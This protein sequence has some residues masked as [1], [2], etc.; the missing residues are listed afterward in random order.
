MPYA[1]LEPAT[2]SWLHA[3]TNR[4]KCAARRVGI[5]L[6]DGFSLLGA[7]LVAELFQTANECAASDPA[8]EAAYDVR[9]LSVDGGSVACS[10]SVRVWTDGLDPRQFIGFDVLFIAG[11]EIGRAH[12]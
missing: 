9:L 12:V 3:S 10:A 7:G 4:S 1:Q 5:L 8:K 6:F 2:V 11:G